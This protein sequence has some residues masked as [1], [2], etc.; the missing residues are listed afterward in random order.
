MA[1]KEVVE[2]V[3]QARQRVPRCNLADEMA[4]YVPLVP[5]FVRLLVGEI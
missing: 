5:Q 2:L 1:H 3:T 4:H